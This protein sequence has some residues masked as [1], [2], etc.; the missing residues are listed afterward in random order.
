MWVP[1]NQ[2]RVSDLLRM[3]CGQPNGGAGTE[4]GSSGKLLSTI[5]NHSAILSSTLYQVT[6]PSSA[7]YTGDRDPDSSPNAGNGKH[8]LGPSPQ[9]AA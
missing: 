3:A 5:V 6:L 9:V 1:R 8:C 2:M 7:V 4:D